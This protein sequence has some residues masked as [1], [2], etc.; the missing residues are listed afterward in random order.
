MRL[1]LLLLL[2]GCASRP[3]FTRAD[4]PKRP[5]DEACDYGEVDCLAH[6]KAEKSF[7][8]LGPL[9]VGGM[10]SEAADVKSCEVYGRI[11]RNRCARDATAPS[12]K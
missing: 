3:A 9:V 4:A 5:C 8:L 10:S 7:F 2:A 6:V 11:C 12:Q 1:C